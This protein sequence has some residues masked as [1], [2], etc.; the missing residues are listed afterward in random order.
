M[1][2]Y[3]SDPHLW[4]IFPLCNLLNAL[5]SIVLAVS[6]FDRLVILVVFVPILLI[7][8]LPLVVSV[9]VAFIYR[10]RILMHECLP[11]I[12]QIGLT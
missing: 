11:G 8:A 10:K 1:Q 7:L 6:D 5:V 12:R 9:Q 2:Q 3:N 4:N